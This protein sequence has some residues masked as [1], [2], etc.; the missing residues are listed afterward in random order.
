MPHCGHQKIEQQKEL[1]SKTCCLHFCDLSRSHISFFWGWG[2][3]DAA[4]LC[5]SL[6]FHV[7]PLFN[8]LICF[9]QKRS[10]CVMVRM[11]MFHGAHAS[12]PLETTVKTDVT[13]V[14]TIRAHTDLDR[15]FSFLPSLPPHTT[16]PQTTFC[17]IGCQSRK[18]RAVHMSNCNPMATRCSH[19]HHSLKRAWKSPGERKKAQESAREP[20][21]MT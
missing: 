8:F 20:C 7:S 3:S 16:S 12:F 14:G 15:P 10:I 21:P 6:C 1:Q 9:S 2:H 11:A 4:P 18:L 13:K 19:I 5:H 17:D